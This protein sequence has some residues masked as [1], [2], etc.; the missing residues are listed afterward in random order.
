MPKK[1]SL[2]TD[3]R[4]LQR[5]DAGYSYRDAAEHAGVSLSYVQKLVKGARDQRRNVQIEVKQEAKL[6]GPIP[7]DELSPN[8]QRAWDDFPFFQEH[9][10]GRYPETWQEEAAV[11]CVELLTVEEESYLL[12]NCPPGSGKTTLMHDI[13]AW[14]T[15]RDRTIRGQFGSITSSNASKYLRRLRETLQYPVPI[16][17]NARDLKNGWAKDALG[18]IAADFGRFRPV[19]RDVWTRDGF[20]VVQHGNIKSTQKE[21]TWSSYGIDAGFIGGRFD[22]VIW[23]DLVDPKKHRTED[24]RRQLERDYDDLCET[25]LEPFGL[26]ALVG[27]RLYSDDLYH[28]CTEKVA[29]DEIDAS[30]EATNQR[31]KYIHIKYPAH[32]VDKCTEGSH[33]KDAPGY[34]DGCLLSPKRLP[35]LKLASVK[36]SPGSNFEVVYQQEDIDP[37]NVLVPRNWVYGDESHIGC[38]DNYR[39]RLE[40]PGNGHMTGF[41]SILTVDPSPTNYWAIEWWLVHPES[42]QYFLIDL[43]KRKMEAPEFLGYNQDER[44]YYGVAD[45]MVLYA[46]SKGVPI[47]HIIVEAVAAQRF[48]VQY[49]HYK[50]WARKHH[51]TTIP[52]QT[53][54][55][56][57]DPK[58]GVETIAPYWEFGHIR[59]PMK[60][61]LSRV[62]SLQLITEVTHYV[63]DPPDDCLMAEWFMHWNFDKIYNP[64]HEPHKDWRPGWMKKDD[65]GSSRASKVLFARPTGELYEAPRP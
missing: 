50:A 25:R 38:L 3:R 65:Q 49:D 44:D 34:P 45:E 27:Q 19:E 11:K 10:L 28:Y 61:N 43:V 12:I 36:S 21:F 64:P 59:L 14:A 26:L 41:L 31:R 2:D 62:M 52:H 17:A 22:F 7:W 48:L 5:L 1:I 18:C 23:D 56:K 13:A 32:F 16:P 42:E 55:N 51:I 63:G 29:F 53:N 8:A 24:A 6:R 54:R 37:T 47:T 4:V 9:Y 15:L 20:V 60:G 33:S 46:E 39:E 57:S 35:Y 58:Y 30:G 40:I